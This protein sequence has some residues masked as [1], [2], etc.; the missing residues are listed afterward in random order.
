MAGFVGAGFVVEQLA[1]DLH[2]VVHVAE[3]HGRI[4]AFLRLENLPVDRL[5]VQSRRC[6]GLQSA[7][8]EASFP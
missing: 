4:V 6:S 3:G 2:A 1:L 7:E 8:C 5:C